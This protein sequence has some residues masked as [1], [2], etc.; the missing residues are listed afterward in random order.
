[1]TRGCG[2][3]GWLECPAEEALDSL[4]VAPGGEQEIDRLAVF[5]NGPVKVFV[6]AFNSDVC[7][8]YAIALRGR[9]EM[10]SATLLQLRAVD[11]N[12]PPDAAG[13][14]GQPSLPHQLGDMRISERVAEVVAD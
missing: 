11:L 1:M 14:D 12:P 4:G 13:I 8:I 9:L 2:F 6:L 10:G 3:P 5:V 7:F